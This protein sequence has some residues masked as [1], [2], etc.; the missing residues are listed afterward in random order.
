MAENW[1]LIQGTADSLTIQVA[2]GSGLPV[3]G[4]Y[5]GS[6]ALSVEIWTGDDQAP[7]TLSGTAASWSDA[8]NGLILL[9]ISQTDTSAMSPGIYRVRVYVT[10]SSVKQAVYE[11]TFDVHPHA[12]TAST[13]ATY[14]TYDDMQRL[15]PWIR[16]LVSTDPAMLS[17][18]AEYRTQARKWIDRQIMSRVRRTLE[19][20]NRRHAPVLYVTQPDA[21][22]GVDDGP[23]WGDSIY[24]HATIDAQMQTIQGW[25][26]A[27]GLQLTDGIISRIAAL[28]SIAEL[29]Q[30]Q[31]GDGP[32]ETS[33]QV[34]AGQYRGQ[35]W[36]DWCYAVPR[37]VSTDGNNTVLELHP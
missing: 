8:S 10:K 15:A 20:Q 4:V 27:N 21:N 11:C 7:L 5:T 34:L 32:N 18:L 3:T 12:G 29:C 17:S 37:I 13:P 9:S 30:S 19:E 26:D 25:L 6:D 24:P 1:D 36:R 31:L 28:R 16:R 35:S 14:C 33:F 23:W 22:T 2:N